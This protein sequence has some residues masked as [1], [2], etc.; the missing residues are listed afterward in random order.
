MGGAPRAIDLKN[1]HVTIG[2]CNCII[3]NLRSSNINFFLN[4]R[5]SGIWLVLDV[6]DISFSMFDCFRCCFLLNLIESDI[7]TLDDLLGFRI[8]QLVAFAVAVIADKNAFDCLWLELGTF[9]V[10]YMCIG[11]ASECS[12]VTN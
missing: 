5:S 11:F 4:V 8:E 6:A 1:N 12:K 9:F 2:V 3:L 7:V 10:R